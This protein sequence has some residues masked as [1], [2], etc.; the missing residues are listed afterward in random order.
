MPANI[1]MI[2]TITIAMNKT[3]YYYF[4]Y[5]YD[6]YYYYNSMRKKFLLRRGG[7]RGSCYG[8]AWFLSRVDPWFLSRSSCYDPLVPVTPFT[9]LLYGTT[10]NCL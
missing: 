3:N 7:G 10:E 4:Y 6:Y 2:I 8:V 5:Y 1:T 9:P